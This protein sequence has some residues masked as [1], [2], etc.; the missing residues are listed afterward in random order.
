MPVVNKI[1]YSSRSVVTPMPNV[2]VA[3]QWAYSPA[4]VPMAILTGKLATERILKK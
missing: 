4:G 1:Q 2:F 3:G